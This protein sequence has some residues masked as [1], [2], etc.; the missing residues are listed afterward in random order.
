MNGFFPKSWMPVLIF[1][2]LNGCSPHSLMKPD[3]HSCTVEEQEWKTF[4]WNELVGKWKGSVEKMRN[5]SGA[6]KKV[7]TDKFAELN[8][9]KAESFLQAW[10]GSCKGLPRNAIVLNGVLW[11]GG[12][13]G[14]KEYEAFVPVE[15]DRVAYGRLTLNQL[16]GQ[17]ICQFRRLG[18]VMGKNRLNLP[19]V[20]FSD[21]AITGSRAPASLEGQE[22]YSV[23]FLRFAMNDKVVTAFQ[24][25]GRRP[26]S[27]QEQ[28]RP[29]LIFRV[30]RIKS[31]PK[32]EGRSEWQE[33]EEYIY[34]LWKSK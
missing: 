23:E 28:E 3:C 14:I 18:R 26:A 8:F 12:G 32:A 16:N 13:Q 20:S 7:K 5:V 17:G 2:A 1:L 11:E 33:T 31:K 30:F 24:T 6:E 25:D 22:D 4:S 34:R 9:V 10:G 19:T 29:S 21:R 15:D 27:V